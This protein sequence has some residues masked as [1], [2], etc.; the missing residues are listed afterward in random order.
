MAQPWLHCGCSE[1]V[2]QRL[3]AE[4]S[5]PSW[6][7]DLTETLQFSTVVIALDALHCNHQGIK[8][9]SGQ[10][11]ILLP[12]HGAGVGSQRRMSDNCYR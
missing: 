8:I 1:A 4:V 9:C 10:L 3:Q 5:S 6:R 11:T 12:S 2:P 7:I